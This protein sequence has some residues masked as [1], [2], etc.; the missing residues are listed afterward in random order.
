MRLFRGWTCPQGLPPGCRGLL[1]VENHVDVIVEAACSTPR[2]CWSSSETSPYADE[3]TARIHRVLAGDRVR[4]SAQRSMGPRVA[5]RPH[6]G[7]LV[8]SRCHPWAGTN[9]PSCAIGAGGR[10]GRAFDVS[11]NC[12]VLARPGRTGPRPTTWLPWSHPASSPTLGPQAA[13]RR[14]VSGERAATLLTGF[15]GVGYEALARLAPPAEGPTP[16][17]TRTL[18]SGA[19]KVSL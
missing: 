9:P 12:E 3:Y 11:F 17:A 5:G 13:L 6:A 18:S 7:A 1:E 15:Q 16:F 8:Y 10:G 4:S 14:G 2:C 19:G